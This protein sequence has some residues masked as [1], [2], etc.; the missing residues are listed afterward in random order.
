MPSPLNLIIITSDEMRGDIPSYMGN[1]DCKTPS[2]DRL[3]EQSVAFDQHFT[4]HG[5]CVPS[6]CALITG[7]YAHTDGFRTVNKTN[8]LPPGTP[9][10]LTA[11]KA[12][13]YETA[14][15]GHNHM[16]ADLWGDNSKGS[17]CTDYHSYTTDIFQPFT[18]HKHEVQQP[19]ENSA[20][21]RI[22]ADAVNHEVARRTEPL[23]GFCDDNRA[24]QAV[25]YLKTL[26]DRSR[27]FYMQC[28]F[29]APHPGYAVEEPYFSMYDRQGI[30]PY[31]YGLPENAALPLSA[32][33]EIRTGEVACEEDFRQLQAVYYGMC[34]KVDML[35]GRVLSAIEEEGLFENTVILF[36]TDHGDFAGQY[37]LMEK[38]DTAMQDCIMHVPAMLRAP[39][40]PAGQRVDSLTEHT[41]LAPTVLELLGVEPDWGIHGES[42]L[43]IIRGDKR[44]EAVF[45]DGGHDPDMLRRFNGP[46]TQNKKGREVPATLGKQ[47]TYKRYP[48]SMARTKMVRTDRWKLVVRLAG[49]NELYDMQQDPDEMNNLYGQPG[50]EDVV[51]DLQ[52]RMLEWCLRTDTDLPYQEK[53]GA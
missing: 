33:R 31:P 50:H 24:E 41:D 44:K 13:G 40:L 46:L 47:D 11:L 30:R 23:T 27:P 39:G 19:D 52:L 49:G 10:V 12:Q 42:L 22:N 9:N 36:T 38:W 7:R 32:M 28:D 37:G 6:R 5:K 26:R 4:V 15:F 43:P 3:A 21:I 2:L 16:W 18:Q 51:R 45:A 34:T 14:A 53:V 17:G 48:D 29:S 8:L 35:I 20:P 1:P 25:H